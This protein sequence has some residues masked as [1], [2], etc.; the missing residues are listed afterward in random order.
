MV[1]NEVTKGIP[2]EGTRGCRDCEAGG[3]SSLDREWRALKEQEE[4]GTKAFERPAKGL[5]PPVKDNGHP[6]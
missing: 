1:S 3:D 6:L 4:L 2:G 5:G